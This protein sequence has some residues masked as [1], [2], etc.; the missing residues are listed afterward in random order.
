MIVDYCDSNINKLE[1]SVD[2]KNRS[3]NHINKLIA[4]QDALNNNIKIDAFNINNI[5]IKQM[6]K[7]EE[8]KMRQNEEQVFKFLSKFCEVEK[9]KIDEH[10]GE[11]EDNIS[12][13]DKDIYM[14]EHEICDDIKLTNFSKIIKLKEKDLSHYEDENFMIQNNY[15]NS[16]D[17]KNTDKTYK[18]K[19]MLKN[20]KM[21]QVN[22]E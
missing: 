17:N 13:N 8:I 18:F 16:N 12:H 4:I 19:K 22:Y 7:T 5:K 14:D 2:N 20:T 1:N 15:S 21:R 11:C 10:D 3:Q 6:D 9:E